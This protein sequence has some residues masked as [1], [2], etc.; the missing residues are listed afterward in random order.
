[1]QQLSD[2]QLEALVERAAERG[3]QRALHSLGLHDDGAPRDVAELRGL[4]DAWRLV[5]RTAIKTATGWLTAGLL[6]GIALA[7]GFK[8]WKDGQ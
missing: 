3:A 5:K 8:I 6:T 2:A 1:M 7:L 4:L